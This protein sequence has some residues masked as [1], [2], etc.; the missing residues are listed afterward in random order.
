MATANASA[1]SGRALLDLTSYARRGPGRRDRVPAEEVALIARTVRHTPEVMVK[2]LT[3][4]SINVGGVVRHFAYLGRDGELALETDDG[5]QLAGRALGKDLANRWDLDLEEYGRSADVSENRGRPPARLVHKLLFSMPAGTPP[6]AVLKGTRNFLREEFGLKHRYA[7]VLHT[8]EPHPHVHAVVKAVSEQGIRLHITKATLRFWRHEFARHLR[9]QGIEA[10]ATERS[11][12]GQ[13]RTSKLDP[14][15][16][17]AERGCSYHVADRVREVQR[18]LAAGG[19]DIEEA[20]QLRK[21]RSV[22]VRGWET[23]ADVLRR[24]GRQQSADEVAR[25]VDRMQPARSDREW[26]ARDIMDL[27]LQL[28]GEERT[29]TR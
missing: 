1:F 4:G 8:D 16:R 28:R 26:L 27:A 19:V 5:E 7:F 2:V 18:A 24:D 21:T 17:A 25:F 20:T 9:T 6:Q 10:N 15:Y 11:V 14:I 12:R 23:I 29:I 13:S 22:V 3:R